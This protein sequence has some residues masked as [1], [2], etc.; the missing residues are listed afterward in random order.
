M[1]KRE[2][3]QNHGLPQDNET[4][5]RSDPNHDQFR[6]TEKGKTRKSDAEQK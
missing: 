6:K 3:E 2:R 5:Y 4:N 1:Q